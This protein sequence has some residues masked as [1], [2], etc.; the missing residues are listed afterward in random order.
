M[1]LLTLLAAALIALA[2]VENAGPPFI[3]VPNIGYIVDPGLKTHRAFKSLNVA[4]FQ[5]W[6]RE[7]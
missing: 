7:G 3:K 6:E 5:S 4:T 2:H 1:L